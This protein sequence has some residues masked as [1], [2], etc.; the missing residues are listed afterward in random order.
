MDKI[1][2]E[3]KSKQLHNKKCLNM[4]MV[5]ILSGKLYNI[6]TLELTEVKFIKV[7]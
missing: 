1:R 4:E 3:Q 2:F 5:T 7:K 6:L